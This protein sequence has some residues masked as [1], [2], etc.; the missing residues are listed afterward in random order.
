MERKKVRFL[1]LVYIKTEDSYSDITKNIET[2]FD[3]SNYELD[4]CLREI[5]MK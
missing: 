3:A 2:R 5:I 1:F 4:H